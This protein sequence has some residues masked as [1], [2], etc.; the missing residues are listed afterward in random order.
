MTKNYLVQKCRTEEIPGKM[1]LVLYKLWV[2]YQDVCANNDVYNIP[3]AFKVDFVG[4]SVSQQHF[5]Q[6]LLNPLSCNCQLNMKRDHFKK[7]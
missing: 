4:F 5:L 2:S 3:R 1:I 7:Q 6:L